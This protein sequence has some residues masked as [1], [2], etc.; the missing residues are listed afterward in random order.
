MCHEWT[1]KAAGDATKPSFL[2]RD[3][4]PKK[5]TLRSG[6]DDVET[7][8]CSFLTRAMASSSDSYGTKVPKGEDVMMPDKTK[9]SFCLGG[10]REA[11]RIGCL[12]TS[13]SSI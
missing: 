8:S 13:L 11:P 9:E 1:S 12:S 3:F 6:L 2:I 5:R 7:S 10:A 4:S